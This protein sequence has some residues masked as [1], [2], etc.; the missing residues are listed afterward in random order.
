MKKTKGKI[1]VSGILIST[2]VI[3]GCALSQPAPAVPANNPPSNP[4]APT[5]AAPTSASTVPAAQATSPANQPAGDAQTALTEAFK[6]LN[7]AYPYRLTEATTGGVTLDRVTDFAAADRVHST[8]T[9]SPSPDQK[10]MITIGSQ[11]WWKIN[12]AWDPNPSDTRAPVDIYSL[13]EPNLHDVQAAGQEAANGAP[14]NVYTFNLTI[15]EPDFSLSG[16]GKA[17]VGSADGLPR[18]LDLQATVNGAMVNS[19]LVYS[20]GVQFDIQPPN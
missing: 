6:K 20:Y 16:S 12:G 19:H 13:I 2:L 7:T 5:N 4:A 9:M 17:W 14:C 8:W 3:F 10:E 15:S 18:Q 11:T 1:A